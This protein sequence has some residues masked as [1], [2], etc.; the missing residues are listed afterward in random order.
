MRV[1]V[2]DDGVRAGR[3][4]PETRHG[5]RAVA[6]LVAEHGDDELTVLPERHLGRDVE[7]V[8]LFAAVLLEA[9]DALSILKQNRLDANVRW[10]APS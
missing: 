10:H 2:D 9:P 1:H 8:C 4:S 3:L 5:E 6:A 7:V